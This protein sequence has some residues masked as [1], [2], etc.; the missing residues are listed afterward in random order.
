MKVGL[1]IGLVAVALT[2]AGCGS[3]KKAD[4]T[5][6]ASQV[7]LE[8]KRL[9]DQAQKLALQAQAEEKAKRPDKAIEL[10]QQALAASPDQHWGVWNNLG[11][12]L[13]DRGDYF[14]AASAFRRASELPPRESTPLVN[15]GVTFH[16]AGHDQP[17]LDAFEKALERDPNSLDALRGALVAGQRLRVTSQTALE[18]LDRAVMLERDTAWRVV[19]ERERIAMR[20]RLAEQ[21]KASRPAP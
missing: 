21:A 5:L 7:V 19:F 10:Y 17:A 18:R 20:N 9:N 11:M 16:R 2:C 15:L 1:A 13:L 3:P 6:D 4:P 12:L 14:G 8:R